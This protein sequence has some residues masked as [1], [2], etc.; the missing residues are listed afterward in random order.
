MVYVIHGCI[1]QKDSY[2][3]N[4]FIKDVI[5]ALILFY[6]F[7]ILCYFYIKTEILTGI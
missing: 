5:Q 2:R 3:K 1:K 6:R 7:Y 4:L